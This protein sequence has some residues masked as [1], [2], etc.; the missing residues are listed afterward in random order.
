MGEKGRANIDSMGGEGRFFVSC[1]VDRVRNESSGLRMSSV[2]DSSFSG[3]L[4]CRS[5]LLDFK[6]LTFGPFCVLISTRDSFCC[7]CSEDF[8]SDLFNLEGVP[9]SIDGFFRPG[10]LNF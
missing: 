4:L 7:L 5:S 1:S 2:D 9:L 10:A 8:D 6:T 3:L